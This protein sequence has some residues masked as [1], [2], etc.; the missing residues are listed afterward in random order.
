M[1]RPIPR[2]PCNSTVAV[3]YT[4][5][6]PLHTE[7]QGGRVLAGARAL[8]LMT[9]GNPPWRQIPLV[10]NRNT[11]KPLSTTSST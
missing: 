4:H 2:I 3:G 10:V 5:L 7:S 11:P 6:A 9:V 8:G 1:S